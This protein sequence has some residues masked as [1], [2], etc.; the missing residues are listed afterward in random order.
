VGFGPI[1]IGVLA[2][3]RALPHHQAASPL[4][5]RGPGRAGAHFLKTGLPERADHIWHGRQEV[6]FYSQ[7]AAAMSVRLLPRC[8][9][10]HFDPDSKAWHLLLEDRSLGQT[11]ISATH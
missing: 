6:A 11:A 2:R 4:R 7:I 5:C 9:D 1:G 3:N 8:F 10:A